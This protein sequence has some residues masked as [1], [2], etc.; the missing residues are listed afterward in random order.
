MAPERF[1]GWA[2]PRSDVYSLGMTLYELATLR[3][4]F[5]EPE[6]SELII[7]ILNSSF[8]SPR[9]VESAIPADLETIILKATSR[10]P[11]DRYPSAEAMRDDL[12]RFCEKKPIMARRVT[13]VD[14]LKKWIQRN[15]I[16]AGLTAMLAGVLLFI[17]IGSTVAAFR[18]NSLATELAAEP[19]SGFGAGLSV[20]RDWATKSFRFSVRTNVSSWCFR[21]PRRDSF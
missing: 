20:W 14:R 2:D 4:A 1:D 18:F 19:A 13:V 21:H 9:E 3:P 5:E 12:R 11:A 16:V 6:R 15:P 7:K 10:E 17:A 8:P